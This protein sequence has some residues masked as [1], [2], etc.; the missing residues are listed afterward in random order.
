MGF[1]EGERPWKMM[2]LPG[3]GRANINE[4]EIKRYEREK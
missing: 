3:A 4:K 1:S 2:I